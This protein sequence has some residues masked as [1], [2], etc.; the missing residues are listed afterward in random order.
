MARRAEI[1][2]LFL[3]QYGRGSERETGVRERK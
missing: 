2:R 1:T 3:Q